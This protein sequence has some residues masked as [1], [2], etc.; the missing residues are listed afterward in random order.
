VSV[1]LTDTSLFGEGVKNLSENHNSLTHHLNYLKDVL[2][3]RNFLPM[4]AKIAE[5]K[6]THNLET[7]S[8]SHSQVSLPAEKMY[9][10]NDMHTKIF[11]GSGP[12]TAKIMFLC[13]PPKPEAPD[14]SAFI[15]PAG[16]LLTKMIEAMGL[17]RDQVFL[18]YMKTPTEKIESI[19]VFQPPMI[20]ALGATAGHWL[21]DT[22]KK[23]SEIRG[24]LVQRQNTTCIATFHPSYLLRNAKEKK[25]VWQDLQLVMEV[26]GL[27]RPKVT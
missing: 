15:G 13:E 22:D 12:L 27:S 11:Y 18:A 6:N 24:Q 26:L 4:E 14:D 25:T 20:V 16:E 21:L 19:E 10:L 1:L 3:I 5:E 23:I 17:T 8:E 9:A 7:P 2:G